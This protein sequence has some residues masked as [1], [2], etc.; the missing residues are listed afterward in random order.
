MTNVTNT[1]DPLPKTTRALRR[2]ESLAPRGGTTA[3]HSRVPFATPSPPHARPPIPS[4]AG[5]GVPPARS[6]TGR[7]PRRRR[8][9]HRGTSSRC[10][11][12]CCPT[13]PGDQRVR[14]SRPHAA[15]S[16]SASSGPTRRSRWRTSSASRVV[17]ITTGCCSTASYRTSW[18]RMAIRGAMGA[19]GQGTRFV[20]S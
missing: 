12:S 5:P 14:P 8:V 17:G 19:A 4:S 15:P 18:R 13:S 7:N 11:H 9:L 6:V 16:R 10:G 3:R 1:A 2:C 20:M